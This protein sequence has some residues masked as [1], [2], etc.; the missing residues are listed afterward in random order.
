MDRSPRPHT[1]TVAIQTGLRVSELTVLCC[2]DVHLGPGAY[3]RCL[4]KGRKQRCTPLTAQSVAM[5][6]AWL[7]ERRG[8]SEDPLFPT[9]RG[10]PLSRDAVAL[11]VT[12]QT[13]PPHKNAAPRSARKPLRRTYYVTRQRCVCFTQALTPPSS[14]SGS[15]TKR[16]TPSR[17][18]CTQT[19]RSRNAPSPAPH[20]SARHL[21][22]T[23]HP[24]N[25]STSSK[26]SDYAEHMPVN[27]LLH[28][29]FSSVHGIIRCSA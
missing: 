7:T 23:D 15:G 3:L 9:S 13:P 29:A 27:P 5:L 19:S 18:T 26:H 6:Q 22:D 1:M 2:H 4:G 20:P 16:H 10:H 11:L 28:K 14:R 24:T 25:C 17:F 12:K 21:A 8:R